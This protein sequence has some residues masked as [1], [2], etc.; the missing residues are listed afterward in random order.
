MRIGKDWTGSSPPG[1]DDRGGDRTIGK[2]Q[3]G[4]IG[5]CKINHVLVLLRS[6][7]DRFLQDA[8]FISFPDVRLFRTQV[9][10][11]KLPWVAVYFHSPF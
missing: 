11:A 4:V 6:N 7:E 1:K 3:P 8:K 10:Q 9:R 5:R 2:Q